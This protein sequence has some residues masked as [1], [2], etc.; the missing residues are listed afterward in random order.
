MTNFYNN[1]HYYTDRPLRDWA[2]CAQNKVLMVK[3]VINNSF[4]QCHSNILVSFHPIQ[5]VLDN[6]PTT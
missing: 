1:I 5:L 6:L 4:N 2:A 3:F